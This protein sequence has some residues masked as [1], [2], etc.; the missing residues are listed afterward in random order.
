MLGSVIVSVGG[1]ERF[2]LTHRTLT[3]V[4]VAYRGATRDLVADRALA[5]SDAHVCAGSLDTSVLGYRETEARAEG[6]EQISMS[7]VVTE[8]AILKRR[9]IMYLAG[10]TN[11]GETYQ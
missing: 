6:E 1:I 9:S 5:L 8:A 3:D 7:S 11:R 2:G 10:E 4:R